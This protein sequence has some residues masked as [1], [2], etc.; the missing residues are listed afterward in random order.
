MHSKH[1]TVAVT[2]IHL[3]GFTYEVH[4]A[5]TRLVEHKVDA[6]FQTQSAADFRIAN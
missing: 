4:G 2:A 6:F 5:F 3:S 1:L